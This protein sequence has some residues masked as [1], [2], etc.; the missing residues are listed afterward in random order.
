MTV[1]SHLGR[2]RTTDLRKIVDALLYIASTG[3]QWR[4]LP[5]DFLPYSTVQ[6]YF[7]RWAEDGLL[8]WINHA[9]VVA[10]GREASPS[11]GIIDSQPVKTTEAG[12]P[13]GYD[14]GKKIKGRKRHIDTDTLGSLVGLLVH[15][16]DVQ[17]RDGA[18]RCLA[19]SGGFTRGCGTSLPMAAMPATSSVPNRLGWDAGW[20]RSS[21][22]RSDSLSFGGGRWR[23]SSG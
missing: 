3:C 2:A 4:L 9:L 11:A 12:G 23:S 6:G 13:C 19:A 1:R 18:Q 16:A 17:D 15:A 14:A 21:S 10:A 22:G 5:K 20:S 7:Y 8:F